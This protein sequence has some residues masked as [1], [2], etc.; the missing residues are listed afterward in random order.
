[1]ARFKIKSK[2]TEI[3]VAVSSEIGTQPSEW[4]PS[5]RNSHRSIGYGP[6]FG[7][8]QNVTAIASFQHRPFVR[9]TFS[10]PL[11]FSSSSFKLFLAAKKTPCYQSCP[12]LLEYPL[13]LLY[14]F[15]PSK[16][17]SIMSKDIVPPTSIA[18]LN[19]THVLILKN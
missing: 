16:L 10:L 11:L 1:M 18:I 9:R 13:L 3:S 4:P 7:I 8:P 14:F 6:S 19:E 2:A 17:Q 5:L 12:P 15:S